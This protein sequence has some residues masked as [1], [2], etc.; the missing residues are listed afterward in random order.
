M[1]RTMIGGLAFDNAHSGPTGWPNRL[2]PLLAPDS[3]AVIGASATPGKQGNTAI[4]YLRHAG[5]TGR[6]YPVNPSGGEIEGLPVLAS[7]K[8]VPER[9]DCAFSVVPAAA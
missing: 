9:V 8:D 5:F 6:I 7:I 3:V 4:R 2:R 1:G